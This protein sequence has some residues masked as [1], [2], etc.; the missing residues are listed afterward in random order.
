M[1]SLDDDDESVEEEAEE[2]EE[3]EAEEEAE[4][5]HVVEETPDYAKMT[6]VELKRIASKNG[7]TGYNKLRKQGLV[8]ILTN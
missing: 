6:V 3:A 5:S 7:I 4:F 8:D 2:A 1:G